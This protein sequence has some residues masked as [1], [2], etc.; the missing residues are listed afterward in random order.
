MIQ[1][2]GVSTAIRDTGTNTTDVTGLLP[3]PLT[4]TNGSLA[5]NTVTTLR[6]LSELS[7]GYVQVWNLGR[8]EGLAGCVVLNVGYNGA[9]GTGWIPSARSS[10]PAINR[11]STNIGGRLVLHA[12]SLRCEA[13]GQGLG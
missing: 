7:P 8:A 2:F 4:F 5:G 3:D 6:A 13:P 10:A 9:K 1:N 12:A 11:S